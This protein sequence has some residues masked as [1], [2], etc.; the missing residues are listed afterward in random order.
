MI[1]KLMMRYC[2]HFVSDRRFIEFMWEQVMDYPL[3]LDNPQTFNEKLQWLKLWN[4]DPVYTTLVDKYSVKQYVAEIIGAEHVIPVI[5]V[6]D[7]VEQIDWDTLPKQF[8]IKCS[9]DSG[10]V[11]V[12]RDKASLDIP[13]AIE[14]LK[15][16]LKK[17]YY[18]DGREWPYKYVQRRVFAEKYMEDEFGELRDYKWFCFDGI[19]RA[20]FIAQG[21]H[22]NTE[23]TFDFYDEEFNH[24]PFTNGHPNASFQIKKPREFDEMKHLASVLSQKIPHVRVDFYDVNGQ[25]LFGEFTFFHWGGL[26]PFIP[27][28]YDRVFGDWIVLP[29]RRR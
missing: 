25:I 23:T 16:A 5:G 24:L 18:Y 10:G 1:T 15:R 8:V 26:M 28:E 6:W 13:S 19:P 9:H 11:I 21:R 20:L 4:R 3:N 27:K 14:K 7:S 29:V 17:N 22:N 12:C 2:S